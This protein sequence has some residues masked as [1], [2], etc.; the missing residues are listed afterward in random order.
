MPALLPI[1]LDEPHLV[2]LFCLGLNVPASVRTSLHNLLAL[3]HPEVVSILPQRPSQ[4][5]YRYDQFC[6][7]I[8]KIF[9]LKLWGPPTIFNFW[10]EEGAQPLHLLR[11]NLIMDCRFRRRHHFAI[12]PYIPVSCQQKHRLSYERR[13]KDN[14]KT[15]FGVP[16]EVKNFSK[17]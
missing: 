2:R 9:C 8:F 11:S 13:C 3:V 7:H 15:Y 4:G 16:S 1:P 12:I 10:G 17:K 5:L 14:N 6:F